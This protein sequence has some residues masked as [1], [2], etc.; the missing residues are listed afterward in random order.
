MPE[1]SL[2]TEEEVSLLLPQKEPF[3]LVD[4]LYSCKA[5]LAKTGFNI[6]K[7]HSLVED[8]F[9]SEAGIL[10][11]MAQSIALKAGYLAKHQTQNTPKIGYL[12]A[13]KN[14]KIYHL[15]KVG[16]KITT[17]IKLTHALGTMKRYHAEIKDMH[18]KALA[19]AEITT[20]LAKE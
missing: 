1:K 4:A 9:L 13:I 7:E 3:V 16:Q 20:T 17:Q 19:S 14:A 2:L 15:P 11:N 18:N 12:A 8:G 5:S 10:E 6:P